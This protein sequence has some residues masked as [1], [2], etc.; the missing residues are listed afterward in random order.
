MPRRKGKEKSG[1]KTEPPFP[2]IVTVIWT[3]LY[4]MQIKHERALFSSTNELSTDF[5][6][7]NSTNLGRTQDSNSTFLQVTVQQEFYTI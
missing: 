6:H 2:F 4:I 3:L 7:L 5:I 1:L